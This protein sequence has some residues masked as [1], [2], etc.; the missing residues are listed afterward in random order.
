MKKDINKLE[1]E[2]LEETLEHKFMLNLQWSMLFFCFNHLANTL[3]EEHANGEKLFFQKEFIRNWKKFANENIT[4]TDLEIINNIL[5]SPKN[6]FYSAL[7]NS[8]EVTESTE[9]YQ[10]KYNDIISKIE[11]FFMDT[12]KSSQHKLENEDFDDEDI[13]EDNDLNKF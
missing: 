3:N 13:D 9:I 11:K 2:A 10:A 6:I 1:R 5:N 4:K 8:D 12:S 7:Q